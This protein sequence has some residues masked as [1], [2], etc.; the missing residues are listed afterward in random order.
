MQN[1]N[2]QLHTQQSKINDN[3]QNPQADWHAKHQSNMQN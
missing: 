2:S 3:N 1:K